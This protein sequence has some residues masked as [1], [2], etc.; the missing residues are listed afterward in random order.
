MIAQS[1]SERTREI[2]LRI[3]LGA[4][5]ADVRR[6]VLREGLGLV[7]LAVPFAV[8]GVFAAGKALGGLLFGV[9][10]SDPITVAAAAL[11]LGGVT[12]L[13]CYLPAL[14][15]SRVD[16]TTAMRTAN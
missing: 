13:A 6:M 3:A 11:T 12:L 15:A 9:E 10:A 14:R 4:S 5:N 7:A 8:F 2:G 16:P 1:V